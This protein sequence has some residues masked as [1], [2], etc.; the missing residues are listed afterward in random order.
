MTFNNNNNNNGPL[1][2]MM[3]MMV[4]MKIWHYHCLLNNIFLSAANGQ[5]ILVVGC[6]AKHQ[7]DPVFGIII[8][9]FDN[10]II[11]LTVITRFIII[12][13]NNIYITL[14]MDILWINGMSREWRGRD[15]RTQSE[16]HIVLE[17]G[18]GRGRKN[19]ELNLNINFSVL[20]CTI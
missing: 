20:F 7:N 2:I 15:K 3:M 11:I 8:Y 1:E 19:L 16:I 9:H 5:W 13:F 10:I 17:V 18:G 4:T 6:R 12:I 14:A